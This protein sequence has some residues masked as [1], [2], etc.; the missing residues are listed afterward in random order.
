MGQ[1]IYSNPTQTLKTGSKSNAALKTSTTP[2]KFKFGSL[3]GSRAF[4]APCSKVTATPATVF[5]TVCRS[6]F[7]CQVHRTE[8][9]GDKG[10]VLS[11][12]DNPENFC[13][14]ELDPCTNNEIHR[15]RNPGGAEKT[16]LHPLNKDGRKH[17][18]YQDWHP[19]LCI[20]GDW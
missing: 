5:T 2:E 19:V 15:L 1:D 7:Y 20:S 9:L 13:G 14:Y 8:K 4:L 18:R 3:Q 6:F 17:D 10:V 11:Y 12:S 16:V